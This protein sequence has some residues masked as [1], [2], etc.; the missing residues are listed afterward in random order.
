MSSKHAL[1]L[2]PLNVGILSPNTKNKPSD[3]NTSSVLGEQPR[4]T[5]ELFSFQPSIA[6]KRR[7]ERRRGNL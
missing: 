3:E 7:R 1:G 5:V 6:L 4:R 2:N